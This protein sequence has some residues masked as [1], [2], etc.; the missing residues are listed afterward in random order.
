MASTSPWS[1][2]P[3]RHQPHRLVSGDAVPLVGRG[4]DHPRRALDPR[5]AGALG[6]LAL[7]T[8]PCGGEL[9]GAAGHLDRPLTLPLGLDPVHPPPPPESSHTGDTA[10]SRR[11]RHHAHT[12]S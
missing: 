2:V 1:P 7:T 11:T 6:V 4:V 8:P 9:H 12:A 3:I 5:V 10:P